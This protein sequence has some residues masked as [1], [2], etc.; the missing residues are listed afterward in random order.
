MPNLARFTTF[1]KCAACHA[2]LGAHGIPIAHFHCLKDAEALVRQEIVEHAKEHASGKLEGQ[3]RV[4]GYVAD[5]EHSSW[6][7]IR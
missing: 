7:L 2:A 4:V 6:R 3:A 5:H 1:L